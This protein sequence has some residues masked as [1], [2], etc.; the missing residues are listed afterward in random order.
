MSILTNPREIVNASGTFWRNPSSNW[1]LA[2]Y[3]LPLLSPM[4]AP[5]GLTG[6]HILF[7]PCCHFGYNRAMRRYALI[8][9][10]IGL[11]AIGALV[12]PAGAAQ[13][14]TAAAQQEI[15]A[16]LADLA[17][18]DFLAQ[19]QA[20]QRLIELA[21]TQVAPQVIAI[22]RAS[23]NP[24]PPATV[25]AAIG[26]PAAMAALTT[27]LDADD[28]TPRRNA[29]QVALLQA[30]DRAV[31]ALSIALTSGRPAVRRNAAEVLGFIKSPQAVNSLLRT[32]QQDA[33]PPRPCG[34][35]ARSARPAS[36]LR[37][38]PSPAAIPMRLCAPKRNGP[39]CV[40]GKSSKPPQPLTSTQMPGNGARIRVPGAYG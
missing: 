40:W 2:L 23:D 18:N 6:A 25:L 39:C 32:A 1:C 3:F 35:W 19:E 17:G 11:L 31:P 5:D 36:V 14:Q 21:P 10:W 29:A 27:A 9:I 38:R 33:D 7:S 26:T 24:R 20:A 30:G 28:L 37:S 34:P 13:A 4:C 8:M 15:D 22:F 12:Q 16:L